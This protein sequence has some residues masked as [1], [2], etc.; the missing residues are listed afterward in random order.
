MLD[1]IMI[2]VKLMVKFNKD[3][4]EINYKVLNLD[5]QIIETLEK[6]RLEALRISGISFNDTYHYK[7]LKEQ[8]YL[9][10]GAFYN[11]K[12]VGA[13]YVSPSYNSLYIEQLF[14][15]YELQR[16][17]LHIG[18]NLL[19]YVSTN[20]DIIQDY[21][22]QKFKYSLLEDGRNT[23]SLYSKMGYEK[24]ENMLMRKKI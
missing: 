3:V 13:C 16:T 23:A 18:T 15:S 22:N 9:V 20:K 14:V 11:D 10:F 12:L 24:T 4:M 8:K 5:E 6:L 2:G 19:K 17:E 21:F 1:F 7:Q